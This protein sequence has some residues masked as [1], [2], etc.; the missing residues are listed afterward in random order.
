[1]DGESKKY[2]LVTNERIRKR[3][4]ELLEIKIIILKNNIHPVRR[5]L[6][7]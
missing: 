4:K 1:M 2:G 3:I 7:G 6:V 5:G